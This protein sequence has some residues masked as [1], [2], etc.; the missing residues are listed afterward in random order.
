MQTASLKEKCTL[1]NLSPKH[2]AR[3]QMPVSLSTSQHETWR[4]LAQ[5]LRRELQGETARCAQSNTKK[6]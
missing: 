3:A 4:D 1:H 2:V 6:R 5:G